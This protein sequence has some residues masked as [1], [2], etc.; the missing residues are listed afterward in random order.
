MEFLTAAGKPADKKFVF[1]SE[2][3]KRLQKWREHAKRNPK[4]VPRI[5]FLGLLGGDYDNVESF[6]DHILR[7]VFYGDKE[8]LQ[9][10]LDTVA[11]TKPP[12]EPDMSSERAVIAAFCKL[13]KGRP[14]SK[15]WL[16]DEW[17][18]KTEL[19]EAMFEILKKTGLPRP[20]ER[21][22]KRHIKN[23]GLQGLR[24]ARRKSKQQSKR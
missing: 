18:N 15:F 6:K 9:T 10:L 20:S 13:Y 2:I 17:P 23:A 12:P 7:A 11:L 5:N 24:P 16:R 14:R 19:K 3:F 21:Q 4:S 22:L 1:R 8:F